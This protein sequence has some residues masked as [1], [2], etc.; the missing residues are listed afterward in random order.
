[1]KEVI[2]ELRLGFEG[3]APAEIP[4]EFIGTP[5]GTPVEGYGFHGYGPVKDKF[6]CTYRVIEKETEKKETEK[7][8]TFSFFLDLEEAIYLEDVMLREKSTRRMASETVYGGHIF[9]TCIVGSN[10]LISVP[11]RGFSIRF[12]NGE[13][14]EKFLKMLT[15][16]LDRISLNTELQKLREKLKK[17]RMD[18]IKKQP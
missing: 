4:K 16:F 9:M 1:M 15:E 10:P 6:S 14:Y 5:L 18:N 3:Y 2:T 12:Y 8:A 11:K 13:D 7:E 17:E